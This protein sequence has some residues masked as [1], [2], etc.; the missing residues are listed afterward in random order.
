[1]KQDPSFRQVVRAAVAAAGG[2][3]KVASEMN[4]SPGAV[5]AWVFRETIPAHRVKRLC[6]IGGNVVDPI[7]IL[8]AIERRTVITKAAQQE[9]KATA[10]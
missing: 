10:S 5:R 4:L 9:Q 7:Q 2:T 8:E 1:M 6:E 3:L